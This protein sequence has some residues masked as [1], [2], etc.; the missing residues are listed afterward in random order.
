MFNMHS[1][2]HWFT[3]FASRNYYQRAFLFTS[4]YRASI[5]IHPYIFENFYSVISLSKEKYEILIRLSISKTTRKTT[6]L[7]FPSILR[8]SSNVFQFLLC[9]NCKICVKE[10]HY[11]DEIFAICVVVSPIYSKKNTGE[12]RFSGVFHTIGVINDWSPVSWT[13]HLQNAMKFQ[14]NVILNFK[15]FC[16]FFFRFFFLHI[17]FR[18]ANFQ[19]RLKQR[20]KFL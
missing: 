5:Y 18:I 4:T 7:L 2:K 12:K 14:S 10:T 19:I 11:S 20:I 16:A 1:S 9:S 17:D 6:E 13:T 8:N 15:V 3:N